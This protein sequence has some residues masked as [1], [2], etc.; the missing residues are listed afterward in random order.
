MESNI[1]KIQNEYTLDNMT[2]ETLEEIEWAN[3]YDARIERIK[4]EEKN[5]PTHWIHEM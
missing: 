4:N 5:N 1:D 2:E 3:A